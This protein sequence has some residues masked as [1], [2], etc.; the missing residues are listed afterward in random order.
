M[1]LNPGAK[2]AKTVSNNRYSQ[3]CEQ[4]KEG[5][6]RPVGSLPGKLQQLLASMELLK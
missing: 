3:R 2:I 1:I 4:K 5:L 6:I